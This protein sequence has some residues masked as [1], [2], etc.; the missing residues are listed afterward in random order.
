MVS[1][2]F[3]SRHHF[4]PIEQLGDIYSYNF[5]SK[6]SIVGKLKAFSGHPGWEPLLQSIWIIWRVAFYYYFSITDD[7]SVRFFF[8]VVFG[9]FFI[10]T[11]V[12]SSISIL[13]CWIWL[14]EMKIIYPTSQ[15]RYY[16]CLNKFL[17]FS[18]KF[19][20][21]VNYSEVGKSPHKRLLVCIT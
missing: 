18:W 11:V 21:T 10:D 5:C 15:K 19:A 20:Q 8:F 17:G 6:K 1:T 16:V 13:K 9:L 7:I 2:F 4:L 12:K 14:V 3:D